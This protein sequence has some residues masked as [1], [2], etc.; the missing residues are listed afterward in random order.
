MVSALGQAGFLLCSAPGSWEVL[1]CLGSSSRAVEPLAPSS[2]ATKI[3]ALSVPP[4]QA[5]G[6]CHRCSC[7]SEG[8]KWASGGCSMRGIVSHGVKS[9]L[10]LAVSAQWH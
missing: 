4:A 7:A 1:L 2:K 8:W 5:A 3:P 10:W 9:A 6:R